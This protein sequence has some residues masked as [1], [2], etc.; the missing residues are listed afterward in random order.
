MSEQAAYDLPNTRLLRALD[1]AHEQGFRDFLRDNRHNEKCQAHRKRAANSLKA[2]INR[3]NRDPGPDYHDPYVAAAYIVKY[4]LWHCMMAYWVFKS[5]FDRIDIPD[6]LYIY[7]VAAGTGAGRIG[8]ALALSEHQERPNSYYEPFDP[9]KAMQSAGDYFWEVFR[10]LVGDNPK[11]C[12]SIHELPPSTLKI[13]TAFHLSLPWENRKVEE[14]IINSVQSAICRT[15]PH[16]GLFTCH[17]D[18][19]SSLRKVVGDYYDWDR[20]SKVSIPS[21]GNG[22]KSRSTFYTRCA[23]S[24]GFQTDKGSKVNTW[25][26][27]RFSLPSDSILLRCEREETEAHE[28][29]ED[30]QEL[31]DETEWEQIHEEEILR[32]EEL[33]HWWAYYYDDDYDDDYDES[34]SH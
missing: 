29:E 12:D 6:T 14:D 32:S 16:L 9:S 20:K 13:V 1:K 30:E 33:G 26:R 31:A 2:L 27:H 7:D 11:D 25:S 4:H 22:V 34:E 23:P 10:G 19:W 3:L 15:S 5:I 8:L 18:K 17:K 21:G 24:L 28:R